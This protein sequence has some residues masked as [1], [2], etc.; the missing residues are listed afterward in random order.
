[1]L[2]TK[3]IEFLKKE[4]KKFS[5]QYDVNYNTAYL[6]RICLIDKIFEEENLEE[7]LEYLS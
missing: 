4:R 6:D 1:M 3:A 7:C 5:R 2:D